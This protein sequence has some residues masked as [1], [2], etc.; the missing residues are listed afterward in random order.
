MTLH[1]RSRARRRPRKPVGSRARRS[2]VAVVLL[3][4]LLAAAAVNAT[5]LGSEPPNTGDRSR[6]FRLW[7]S[8]ELWDMAREIRAVTPL[9]DLPYLH[10]NRLAGGGTLTTYPASLGDPEVV[11]DGRDPRAVTDPPRSVPRHVLYRFRIEGLARMDV[12]LDRR[13]DPQL[14]G[15]QAA[16]LEEHMV[17]AGRFRTRHPYAVVAP[18]I[19]RSDTERVRVMAHAGTV[20]FVDERLLAEPAGR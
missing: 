3:S 19:R 12:V 4:A 10:L 18:G 9:R 20:Y 16:R 8:T 6:R 2:G 17:A 5:P 7:D 14:S 11:E 1:A 13:Y 15:E